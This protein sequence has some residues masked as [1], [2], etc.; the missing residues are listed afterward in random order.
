[1]EWYAGMTY[2]IATLLCLAM[3]GI[4]LMPGSFSI[5]LAS[6]FG[7][8][9]YGRIRD[10][11][12][13][14]RYQY[15]LF[16]LPLY[17]IDSKDL[18]KSKKALFIGLGFLWTP[19]H[20]QRRSDLERP[21]WRHLSER[22]SSL[23]YRAVRKFEKIVAGI[24]L[25]SALGRFTACRH[26]LNVLAPIDTV[27]GDPT[28]HG[29]GLPEGESAVALPQTE[30]VGH[31]FVVGTT[32]VGK[33]R[34]A[35]V[36]ITQDIHNDD[37]VIVFDPKGDADLLARIYHEAKKA[38]RLHQLT[39]FHLGFPR[40]SA[41]YNPLG[42]FARITEV[43]GRVSSQLPSAG[44]SAAFREFTWRYVNV[45]AKAATALGKPVSYES[46]L[47]YGSD[48]EPL[49]EEYLK[50]IFASRDVRDWRRRLNEIVQSAEKMGRNAEGRSREAWACVQLFK[51]ERISDDIV[52]FSLVKTFE[53]DKSFYD[54][55][56][57]SLFPLLEKLTSGEV[58]ALLSPDY[59]DQ[60]D[61]RSIFTWMSV[62]GQ[63]G[64][65]YVGLDALTDSEVASAVGASMF[66]DL[67]STA[68][69]IYKYGVHNNLPGE[70]PKARKICIHADEFN[71]LVGPEFVPLLN[72]AGGAGFQVTA[73]TQTLSDIIVRFGDQNKAGQ[74]IGNLGTI[75]MLRV[76]EL[77]TAELLTAQLRD[78]EVRHLELQSLTT[79]SSNPES[80]VDFTSRTGQTIQR[81]RVPLIHPNDL[82]NLPKGHAFSV[83]GGKLHKIRLPLFKQELELPDNIKQ[84]TDVMRV[85]YRAANDDW[86][87][88]PDRWTA[89]NG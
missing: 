83:I 45:I 38:G 70:R 55:L 75:T 27:E 84:M 52:G 66:A 61:D 68:G 49:L 47:E 54:R 46:L 88:L 39:V 63:G 19:Y 79:D 81:Q 60:N 9:A 10:A 64:I 36:L 44:N 50:Y 23:L 42:D 2:L 13:L 76:K 80:A 12:F 58:G 85:K 28:L 40:L 53:Y 48:I 32:R 43:A 77:A 7:W 5:G 20:T 37:V 16:Q 72:K 34:Q 29:V 65:V 33:T 35:E 86:S 1:M 59:F 78:V 56:V 82:L 67:T 87:N 25:L 11:L 6:V 89:I 30:R 24:F 14:Q 41:R 62:I 21:E 3:P 74:V 4:F 57:A 18:P 73:Y 51:K 31:M 69:Q 22:K 8:M 26:H 15:Q 71:E 17:I